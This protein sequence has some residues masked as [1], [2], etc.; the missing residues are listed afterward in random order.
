MET[1]LLR[2]VWPSVSHWITQTTNYCSSSLC[3]RITSTL[4]TRSYLKVS[5]L[6]LRRSLQVYYGENKVR[7]EKHDLDKSKNVSVKETVASKSSN[8]TKDSEVIEEVSSKNVSF[9]ESVDNKFFKD[10]VYAIEE[11][12]F[13]YYNWGKSFKTE[14]NLKEHCDQTHKKIAES[15]HLKCDQCEY[16]NITEKGLR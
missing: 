3:A 13:K 16:I 9:K 1:L 7:R 4:T 6:M 2:S 8:D 11:S 10:F 12:L 5:V 15:L 14:K